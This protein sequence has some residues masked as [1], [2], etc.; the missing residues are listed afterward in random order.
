[1]ICNKNVARNVWDECLH[2]GIFQNNNVL[3]KRLSA[4]KIEVND[5]TSEDESDY[6]TLSD[7]SEESE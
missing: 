7:I 3:R 5:P 4:L 2:I 6:E 1:M